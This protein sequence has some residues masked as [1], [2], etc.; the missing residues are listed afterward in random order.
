MNGAGTLI[1][2][3]STNLDLTVHIGRP[4][5]AGET[6]LAASASTGLGGKGANQAVAALAAGTA[7]ILV[8]PVGDD[9]REALHLLA[10]YGLDTAHVLRRPGPTGRALI[11]LTPD[12]QN[13]IVVIPGAN[14]ALEAG[15]A[16]DIV[17][18]TAGPGDV[19]LVQCEIPLPTVTAVVDA[20]QRAGAR[21]VLNL[22]PWCDLPAATLAVCDPLVVNESEAAGLLGH[23]VDGLEGAR[24]AAG[25]LGARAR[26]VVVTLGADGALLIRAG[27]TP[28]HAPGRRVDVV[29][30]TGAG[31]ATVGTLAAQLANGRDLADALR[32]GNEAGARAVQIPGAQIAQPGR[33][34]AQTPTAGPERRHRSDRFKEAP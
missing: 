33:A 28:L 3:G 14:A 22:A 31:D 19:V 34:A 7:P 29:D 6:V 25:E 23:S 15:A 30:T 9:G 8:T 18:R 10:S 4:P 11:T 12:G 21:V 2:V 27:R 13:S 17:G 20:A 1:V 32:A 16:T 24:A 26:S 5:A